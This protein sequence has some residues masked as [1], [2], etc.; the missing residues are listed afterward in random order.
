M[1][2]RPHNAFAHKCSVRLIVDEGME[3]DAL[4]LVK[5]LPHFQDSITGVVPMFGGKC[6][7]I[8]V[9]T[10]EN[11]SLLAQVGFD[12]DHTVKPLRLLGARSI[13]VSMEYPD[14]E[15]I[16]F[17]KTY[18]KMK[19]GL[20]YNEEFLS[21]DKDLPRKIVTNGVEIHFKYTRQPITCYR[22]GSTE[23]VVQNCPQ[24]ARPAN[25]SPGGNYGLYTLQHRRN[26]YA[27]ELRGSWNLKFFL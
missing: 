22:C 5:S 20:Y 3:L 8:T 2:A 4:T 21:L 27:Y 14:V 9:D 1:A 16:P 11:A 18:G 7:D 15:L 23:H 19:S 24:K 25:V 26:Y 17:L 10:P 13:F 12:Y 6:S